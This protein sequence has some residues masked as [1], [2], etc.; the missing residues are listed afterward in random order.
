[1]ILLALFISTCTNK[2]LLSV[3]KQNRLEYNYQWNLEYFT[4]NKDVNYQESAK[5]HV[6]NLGE[7]KVFK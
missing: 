5:K 1:M 7:T 6:T 2:V 3:F 4:V